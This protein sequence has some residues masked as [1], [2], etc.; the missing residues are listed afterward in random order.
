MG[1]TNF[2]KQSG[3]WLTLYMHLNVELLTCIYFLLF[4]VKALGF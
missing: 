1:V 3:F 4:K 2:Q